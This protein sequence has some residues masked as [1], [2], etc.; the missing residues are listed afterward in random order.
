MDYCNDPA[1]HDAVKACTGA[2]L[3]AVKLMADFRSTCVGKKDCNLNLAQYV[4]NTTGAEARCQLQEKLSRV[5]IQYGCRFDQEGLVNQNLKGLTIACIS[6]L[7]T[8]IWLVEM[9]ATELR[10]KLNSVFYDLSTM[11]TGD[12]TIEVKLTDTV[13]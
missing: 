3:N 4:V 2:H 12:F 6:I 11:T 9:N 1:K 5:Y 8:I 7:A 13:W 10:D